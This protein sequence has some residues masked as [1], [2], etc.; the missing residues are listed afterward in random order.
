AGPPGGPPG[1]RGR[2]A[3]RSRAQPGRPHAAGQRW[4]TVDPD[5]V[6]GRHRRGGTPTVPLPLA[7]APHGRTLFVANGKGLGAGPNP[8]GPDPE[9]GRRRALRM[10]YG[11]DRWNSPQASAARAAVSNSTVP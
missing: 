4:G 6:R 11:S 2:P 10:A 5:P 1:A 7:A 8:R 9:T 3:P